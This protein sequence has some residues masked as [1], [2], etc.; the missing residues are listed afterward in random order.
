[1]R[2]S[3]IVANHKM[4]TPPDE[5]PY[6]Q[7]ISHKYPKTGMPTNA[8]IVI[9]PGFLDIGNA[10]YNLRS[11]RVL[12]GAQDVF[13]EDRGA[14]TGGVSAARLYSEGVTYCIVGHSERREYFGETNETVS[15]KARALLKNGI[16]PIVCVGEG[17][18]CR[19]RGQKAVIEYINGQVLEILRGLELVEIRNLVFA[20]EPIWAIGTGQTATVEQ[21]EKICAL[22]RGVI[23]IHCH[24]K[25]I[26]DE[27]HI[28]YGGSVKP[29]NAA[30]FGAM[31]N[32]DGALVGGASLNADNFIKIIEDFAY[33]GRGPVS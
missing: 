1:M 13:W 8:N 22:I 12:V 15:K 30:S 27:I 3:L 32:I 20:Y 29:E 24:S 25:E 21:A 26:A 17:L 18:E 28:L 14:Y 2:G 7:Q 10:G 6:Y 16:R 5:A 11:S 19:E 31:K 23:E 9:C 33:A 4:E